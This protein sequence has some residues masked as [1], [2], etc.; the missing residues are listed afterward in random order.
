[1]LALTTAHL[2]PGRGIAGDRFYARRGSEAHT[3]AGQSTEGDIALR[4]RLRALD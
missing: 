1:M 2:V 3:N 4:D